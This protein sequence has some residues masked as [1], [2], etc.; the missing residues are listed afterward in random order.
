[1]H[2][3]PDTKI[4]DVYRF[5]G[6][7]AHITRVRKLEGQRD[8]T[9]FLVGQTLNAGAVTAHF[10]ERGSLDEF[11]YLAPPDRWPTPGPD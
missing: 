7:H 5:K 10:E 6:F 2:I 4:A 11:V 9:V 1:M 3:N 8:E